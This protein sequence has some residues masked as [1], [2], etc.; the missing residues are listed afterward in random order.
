LQPL[1]PQ[2][3]SNCEYIEDLTPLKTWYLKDNFDNITKQQEW[4]NVF[5]WPLLFSQDIYKGASSWFV[6]DVAITRRAIAYHKIR[7]DP[8][9]DNV[10]E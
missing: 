1:P 10:L 6:T 2:N 3:Q 9:N 7:L 5:E 8:M 4:D